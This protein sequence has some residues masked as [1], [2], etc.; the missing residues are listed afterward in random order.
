MSR[1]VIPTKINL[2]R[3]RKTLAAA[4]KVR[5]ILEDRRDI[6]LYE[7]NRLVK[8]ANKIQSQLF[9]NLEKAYMYMDLAEAEMGR[10]YLRSAVM[11]ANNKIEVDASIVYIAG[12]KS[13]ELSILRK[14][15]M[16]I[17]SL[18]RATF[19]DAEMVY[20]EKAIETIIL[21]ANIENAIF[22]L[23]KELEQV[24]RQ[25]NALKN[26]IIPNLEKNIKTIKS[27]LEERDREEFV[28]L[29]YFK[30]VILGKRRGR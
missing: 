26:V 8:E 29:K 1:R 15:V 6:L 27:I 11:S 20:I 12:I 5:K 4:R 28:R 10:E 18:L 2:I 16:P 13:S 23:A 22:R 25:I 30:E 9:E 21:I 24:Q 3:L 7:I 17:G 19:L 14:E